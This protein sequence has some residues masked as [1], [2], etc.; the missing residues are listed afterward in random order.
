MIAHDKCFMWQTDSLCGENAWRFMV[1]IH[2]NSARALIDLLRESGFVKKFPED[3]RK[4]SSSEE[5][6]E[7]RNTRFSAYRRDIG[8]TTN[9]IAPHTYYFAILL[10]KALIHIPM[11]TQ[12]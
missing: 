5:M 11:F 4:L 9:N 10:A 8:K 7:W 3:C 12:R 2:E 1:E 6:N